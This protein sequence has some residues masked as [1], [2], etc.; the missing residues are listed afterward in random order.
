M[1]FQTA[2]DTHF[3]IDVLLNVKSCT[4]IS[5][6]SEFST[7]LEI[8]SKYCSCNICA[9]YSSVL[10]LP[11]RW[12]DRAQFLQVSAVPCDK[13]VFYFSR[14]L[15]FELYHGRSRNISVSP[16]TSRSARLLLASCFYCR[17]YHAPWFGGKYETPTPI[18][19][20]RRTNVDNMDNGWDERSF[21]M[22]F[23]TV[24]ST[25]TEHLCYSRNHSRGSHRKIEIV[26]FD[27]ETLPT[28]L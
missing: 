28:F 16:A 2:S 13:E 24:Q 12:Y 9:Y 7:P 5:S 23:A 8:D 20:D 21:A 25:W 22:V 14:W 11:E 15:F 3:P 27:F 26:F 1:F 10:S 4:C 18:R 6:T 17:N 19:V